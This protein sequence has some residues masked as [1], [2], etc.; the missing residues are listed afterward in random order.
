MTASGKQLPPVI[1]LLGGIGSGKSSV[2][3]QFARLGC[4]VVDADAIGHDVLR[5]AAV[6]QALT[7]RF[8]DDILDAAGQVDRRRLAEKAF[9]DGESVAVLDA[10]MEPHLWPRVRAAIESARQSGAPAVVLDAALI[11]EKGLDNLCQAL[12]YIEVPSDVRRTRAQGARGWTPSETARREAVQV[13]LEVKQNRADYTIDNSASTEHTFE[14]VQ[15][16][17]AQLTK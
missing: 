14:Q 7:A 9:A 13:S 11:L 5:E 1:G 15:Q 17:L 8:G 16:I 3:A 10:I 12:V 6:R 4:A 2:A